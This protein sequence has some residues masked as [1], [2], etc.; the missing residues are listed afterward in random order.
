MSSRGPFQ[1][2]LFCDSVT[3]TH[4]QFFLV[5]FP[6]T[7]V[8]KLLT[9]VV[10]S[11]LPLCLCFSCFRLMLFQCLCCQHSHAGCLLQ[12]GGDSAG[13]SKMGPRASR[14]VHGLIPCKGPSLPQGTGA[15]RPAQNQGLKGIVLKSSKRKRNI[16]EHWEGKGDTFPV[17]F[18][19]YCHLLSHPNPLEQAGT[20]G[21]YRAK[22]YSLLQFLPAPHLC[23]FLM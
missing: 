19:P 23:T 3:T 2:K 16:M 14:A 15:G 6:L 9:P 4:L 21:T 1:P 17:C 11:L 18:S 13:S 8:S 20:G 5:I 10:P 22:H 7:L 12:Q